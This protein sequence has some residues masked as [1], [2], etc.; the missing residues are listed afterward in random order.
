MSPLLILHIAL[1]TVLVVAFV[2]RYIALL[3]RKV[4]PQ[5][6]RRPIALLAVALVASG[7]A[8]SIAY[9]APLTTACISSLGII[10]TVVVLEYALQ[11]LAYKLLPAS[12]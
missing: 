10:F 1:G 12:K 11:N 5:T 2:A 7:V 9:K 8:L 4:A 3:A 6:G